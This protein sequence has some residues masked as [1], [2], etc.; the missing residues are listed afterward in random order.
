MSANYLSTSS[1]IRPVKKDFQHVRGVCLLECP[2]IGGNTVVL[3]PKIGRVKDF[4]SITRL[5]SR[6]CIRV[7]I[8]NVKRKKHKTKKAKETKEEKRRSVQNLTGFD[9]IFCELALCTFNLLDRVLNLCL[10]FI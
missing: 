2:I 3:L 7:R 9:Y 4:L 1:R 5:Y 10:L 8:F 6:M